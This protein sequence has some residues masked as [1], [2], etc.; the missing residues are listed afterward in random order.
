MSVQNSP[1][2]PAESIQDLVRFAARDQPDAIALLSPDRTPL[3]YK[4]LWKRIQDTI[5]AL[6]ALGLG[7]GDCIATVLPDGPEAAV[8]MLSISAFAACAPISAAW[9][10]GE[11]EQSLRTLEP[12][13]VMVPAGAE[14]A[15]R[16][17]KSLGILVIKV[18][19]LTDGEAGAFTLTARGKRRSP[20]GNQRHEAALILQTSGTTSRPKLV[21]HTPRSLYW[22]AHFIGEALALTPG[23]R[24]LNL[25]PLPHSLGLTGGLVASIA[26]GGST[27]CPRGFRT[28]DFFRWLDEFSPTWYGAVPAIHESILKAAAE[29]REVIARS[30][31]RFT[32]SAGTSASPHFKEQVEQAMGCPLIEAY[33]MSEAPPITM[34]PLPPARRKAGSVGVAAGTSIEVVDELG[35]PLPRGQRGEIVVCGSNVTPGYWNNPAANR[36][37]FIGVASRTGRWFRTGDQGYMDD[38]G[39]LFLTGRIKELINRGG[40]KIAPLEVDE[41][42]LEHPAVA[43]AVTFA[44]PDSKLGEEIGA[45]VVLRENM[46]AG[47]AD[48]RVFAATRLAAHK[49]PRYVVFLKELPGGP[50]GKVSRIKLAQSLAPGLAGGLAELVNGVSPIHARPPIEAP[51]GDRERLIAGIWASVLGIDEAGIGIHDNFFDRGGDSIRGAEL[52][53]R[54]SQAIGIETPPL[55]ILLMAPTLAA[56]SRVIDDPTC[57]AINS[58]IAPIQTRGDRTPFFCIG[59]G[60]E[61]RH[62]AAHLDGQPCFGIRLPRFE[63]DPPPLRIEDLAARCR[64]TLQSVQPHGPYMLG[65]WCFAGVVAFELARQLETLGEHVSVLALFDSRNL[66]HGRAPGSRRLQSP[67][68]GIGGKLR[69]HFKRIRERGVQRGLQYAWLRMQTVMRRGLRTLWSVPYRFCAAAGRPLPGPLRSSDFVQSLALR[70]YAPRPIAGSIALFL[71]ADRPRG[72]HDANSEWAHL[73]KGGLELHEIPGDHISMFQEPGVSVLASTLRDY[74]R[75]AGVRNGHVAV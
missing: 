21:V 58:R 31:L 63:A 47:V 39:F 62:M 56:L 44:V 1:S 38:D 34:D 65:G 59:D 11:L 46:T 54:V 75:E 26:S 49:V 37:A 43:R 28:G 60:L 24:C 42:L 5:A 10:K 8:A 70:D 18:N 53:V 7:P 32:R 52:L 45:A 4:N 72:G 2:A 13:A 50:T 33:G 64:E 73:A 71:A 19:P 25:A 6:T 74:L 68:S 14:M 55:S 16:V 22:A 27:V 40:E 3:N 41:A 51:S 12:A 15:A 17:A 48:L 35:N 29:H 9:Q 23:D 30:R 61:F 36:D 57:L 67:W 66:L 69:F 20:A